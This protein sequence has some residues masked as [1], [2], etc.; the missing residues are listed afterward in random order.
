M[1]TDGSQT[2]WVRIQ[3]LTLIA[4]EPLVNTL[5]LRFSSVSDD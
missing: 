5:C 1:S 3:A 2:V 4:V